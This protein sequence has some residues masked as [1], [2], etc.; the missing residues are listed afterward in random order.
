MHSLFADLRFA[1]RSFRK[2]PVFTAIAV[3]SLALGIGANTAIFTLLDQVLLRLLPVKD[4]QQ[5]VL[6]TMRGR[7][8][9]SNWGANAISFPMYRDF[10]DHNQVFSAMFC[11][12]AFFTSVSFAGQT[13]RAPAELVS[14]T[15]FPTLGVGAAIGRVFTADDD[16][17][18]DAPP[19]V[20]L[21]YEYWQT[22]FGADRGILGKTLTVDDHNLTIVGVAQ[23]GFE[24]VQLGFTPDF[25]VPIT[26]ARQFSVGPKEPF[27]DRRSRWVNAFGRMKPGVS[28]TA[29]KASLQPYMHSMLE[30]EVQQAAFAHASPYDREQFL[31]CWMDVLPGSQ[32]QT[33]VQQQLSTPLWVL[34]AITGA[35]LLIACANIANLLL[36]RAAGRQ[37]EIAVRLAMGASRLRLMRQL[38]IESLALAAMGAAAGLALAYWGDRLMMATFV[39]AD[40]GFKLAASPDLRILWFTLAVTA[41]TGV[42]FGMAPAIQS[43]NPDVGPTLKDQAG[44]VVGGGSGALLRK[45]LVVAQV[46][47]SL[48][49]LIGAGLF[50]RSLNRLLTLSPGFPVE[51]LLGFELDPSLSGYKTDRAKLFY[52]RLRENLGAVPG[53]RS[54]GLANMRILENNEWDSSMTVE[55]YVAP[56][57]GSHPEPYM[58]SIS[59]NYFATMGIP[60]LEGRDFNLHDTNR[61]KST[62]RPDSSEPDKIIINETFAKRY[63]AG[64]DPI[65]RHV[66]FGEDP[67]TPTPMEVIG[68]VKDTKYTGLRDEIPEQA[69]VPYL[70]STDPDE[71][72]VYVR[73]SLDPDQFFS[74]ARAKVRELDPNVPVYAMR[75][76]ETQIR[77]SLTTERL[78]ASLSSIFGFL[79]TLLAMVGLY[80]VMA[81]T[82]ARRTREIGIRMA[83]GAER[84][85]VVWMVMREVVLLVAIGV[86]LGLP[87]ALALAGLVKAQL[88][89]LAPNDPAT[90]AMAVVGLAVVAALAGYVPALRASRVDPMTALRYE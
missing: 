12:R 59:P 5:L 15:Y 30:M 23:A 76:M 25:F 47:L 19:L 79:A 63:F 69:F 24:G 66:G 41:L 62:V 72:T 53:V 52:E 82:V 89:G 84:G 44:A 87:A 73:T 2:A 81:Y 71:M 86:A 39:S 43:T 85:N 80:G 70:A 45:A 74:I 36:A 37:K 38:L 54:V 33:L 17:A 75:T 40:S 7:H 42:L 35:V 50:V 78:I 90:M 22:R 13:E 56:R 83:L 4:P 48:L 18:F 6:L 88:F 77:N 20:V 67:G 1:F 58:N 46:S 21:A 26:M 57:A 8:Y 34:M 16:R 27:T 61:V 51:R 32:G 68:V 10:E 9:G 31:K 11:R 64:R 29:A 28:L 55:G 14:G 3:L 49:L 65:G 60:I